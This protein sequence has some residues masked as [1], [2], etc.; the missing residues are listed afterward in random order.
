[1]FQYII[2]NIDTAT[3]VT[4]LESHNY[5][6]PANVETVI[7]DVQFDPT[8]SAAPAGQESKAQY[9]IKIGSKTVGPFNIGA[10]AFRKLIQ[11]SVTPLSTVNTVITIISDNQNFMTS[12][13]ISEGLFYYPKVMTNGQCVSSCPVKP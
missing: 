6:I 10:T 2:T 1:M 13:K 7:F 8:G 4:V 12:I 5:V 11:Q 9:T 3:K